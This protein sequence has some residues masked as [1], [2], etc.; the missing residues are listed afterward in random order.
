MASTKTRDQQKGLSLIEIIVTIFVCSVALIMVLNLLT[1]SIKAAA[2][3]KADL[4]AANLA[5][6]GIELIRYNR[7]ISDWVVWHSSVVNGD[8]RVQYNS[9]SLL[10]YSETPLKIDGDG[11]YQYDAGTNTPFYRKITLAKVSDDE[12]QVLVE[13][14][15]R[16]VNNVWRY[17]KVEDRLW[18]WRK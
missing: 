14:K 9:S 6:E 15:W 13:I 2:V 17:L 1:F 3:S 11:F 12:L 8:Y 18:N 7:E 4:I 10:A 5:Q 16:D